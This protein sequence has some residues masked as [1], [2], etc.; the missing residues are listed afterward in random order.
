MFVFD[1]E[2]IASGCSQ[3]CGGCIAPLHYPGYGSDENQKSSTVDLK[4]DMKRIFTDRKRR[5][6]L[7]TCRM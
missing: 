2:Q 1:I 7:L 3:I 4:A 6:K 5:F